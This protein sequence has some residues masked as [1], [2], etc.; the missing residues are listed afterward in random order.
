MAIQSEYGF[1]RPLTVDEHDLIE[2][3]LGA[4]RS[5]VSR[6]IGQ[7]E[8]AVV[9]GGCGCGCPSVNLIVGAADAEGAP[10]PI[11]LA[12]AESPEGVPV[13][14]I[15]WARGGC[16]SGLEVHPWDGSEVIRLPDAETL[17]NLRIP[18]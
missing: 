5:G 8:S 3:M 6:Y 11:L 15:L 9:V 17:R 10:S 14:L 16:L 7:L 4:V 2:A 18:S 13:G 12:D 1:P